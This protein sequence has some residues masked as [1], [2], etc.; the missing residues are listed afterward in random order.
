[1]RKRA[2]DEQTSVSGKSARTGAQQSA[3]HVSL[4]TADIAGSAYV[5][6]TKE[7]QRAYEHL[8][9]DIAALV[10]DVPH[11]MLS[12]FAEEVLFR[13]KNDAVVPRDKRRAVEREVFQ[14]ALTD[15]QYTMLTTAANSITDFVD[16]IDGAARGDGADTAAVDGDNGVSLVF[17]DDDDDDD[18][19]N[20]EG[21]AAYEVR[22]GSEDSDGDDR[23]DA[24]DVRDGG[25][26][27][28]ARGEDMATDDDGAEDGEIDPT[29]IDAHWLQRQV[30]KAVT[31]DAH[32][33]QELA[34][35]IFAALESA[36]D[37][38]VAE[39]ELLTLLQYDH[40]DLIKMLCVNR[41]AIVYCTRLLRAAG[42][43]EARAAIEEQMRADPELVR[44]LERLQRTRVA[45]ERV[46]PRGALGAMAA[47]AKSAHSKQQQQQQ[48]DENDEN[49]ETKPLKLLDIEAMAFAEGGHLM[50]N[51]QC[52][53]PPD[54][55]SV[56]GKGYTTIHIPARIAPKQENERL[57]PLEALPEWA[58]DGFAGMQSFN[59]VQS[60]VFETAFQGVDNMLIC[61]PTGSGKT[62]IAMLAIMHEL[63]MH[64]D[65]AGVL[66]LADF[67]IVYVAPMKALVQEVVQN[68]S[69]RLGTYG[70]VVRELS[71]DQNL[72]KQQIDETQIIVTTPE[73]WDIVTRKAGERTYTQLVRLLI[74]DEIHLLHDDRGP[75][76]EAL[77][78]RTIRQ[79]E[80]TQQMVRIV[81]LSATLPNYE[82]VATFLRVVPDNVFYFDNSYRPVPL[83]QT[84]IGISEKKG[85]KR[86]NLM[87]QICFERVMEHAI[88]GYTPNGPDGKPAAKPR[89]AAAADAKKGTQV[90]VF[91]H[92]RKETAATARMLKERAEA[93]DRLEQL[94]PEKSSALVLRTE[95]AKMQNAD[96]RELLPYGLG[97]HHAGLS[98]VD[99]T[100]VED[101]FADGHIRVLCS[102]ATLAWG[103]NLPA[104]AVVIKGTQVYNPEK[105]AWTELSIMDIMQMLGRAGRPA[106]DKTGE[107]II[108][109]S[110]T[111]MQFY[112]S[113]M[114]QQLPI[115]SQFMA[116]LADMMLGEIV[117]G[118]VGTIREAVEWLGYTY[119]YICMLRNPALYQVSYES[120]AADPLL[121]GRRADVAHSA[122]VL[123]ERCALIAYDKR[124]G[125]LRCTDAGRVA[126]HF[127]VSHSSMAT[128]HEHLKPSM[129][130]I[131]L[132][133][134]FALSSEFK[135]MSVRREERLELA[136]LLLRVPVPVKEGV[137]EHT[138]KVNVLLQA[139]ISRLSLDG[140]ALVADLVYVTQSAGRI[141]RA[142]YELVLK[143]GWAQLA[144]RVLLLAKML[145]Q[146]QWSTMSPLRQFGDVPPELIKR[147]ESKDF[148]LDRLNE[149]NSQEL[150]ALVRMPAQGAFLFERIHQCPRVSLAA[151]VQPLTRSMLRIELT[152]TP[153]FQYDAERHGP[154][155][156]F[157]VT[158]EDCDGEHILHSEPLVIKQRYA[159]DEHTLSFT[160]PLTDPLPPHYFVRV[161]ADRWLVPDALLP[162]SFAKLL[163][164]EQFPPHTELLDMAPIDVAANDGAAFGHN[165]AHAQHFLRRNVRQFNAI[166]TQTFK[167]LYG[168]DDSV[169]VAAPVGSGLSVCAELAVLRTLAEPAPSGKAAAA[170]GARV[171]YVVAHDVLAAQ[172]AATWTE[173]FA[174]LGKRVALFGADSTAN[175]AALKSSDIVVSTAENWDVVSRRWRQRKN[176]QNVRLYV[177]DQL[178]LI[179]GDAGA[180]LEVVVSRAR[181]VAAQIE[182]PTRIVALATPLANARTLAEWI[183][184]PSRACF[185]FVPSMRPVPLDLV[186]N[187]FDGPSNDAMLLAMSKPAVQTVRRQAGNDPVLVF[188]PDRR[189]AR[190]L[191]RDLITFGEAAR[192]AARAAN[193]DVA[194]EVRDDVERPFLHCKPAALE[195]HLEQVKLR[196]L[197]ESLAFGVGFY[198]EALEDGERRVV[199]QLFASGAVQVVVATHAM[200]YQLP[201]RARLVVV[202]GTQLFDGREHR[203]VDMPIAHVLHMM[204]KAGRQGVDRSGA[205]VIMCSTAKKAFFKK[206]LFEPLPVESHLDHTLADHFNAEVVAQTID[207]KQAAVD[208]LTWTF[209]Y[210]R[211]TQNPNYYGL[212]E[213]GPQQVSDHLSQLVETTLG[214]LEQSK[215]IAINDDADSVTPLNLGII[216]SYYH[217]RYT[218]IELFSLSLKRTTKLAAL[219]QILAE[220]SEY[221]SVPVRRGDERDMR[222]L[223]L[224]SPLK[225]ES[226]RYYDPHIKTNLLL[227]AHFSRRG[228][229]GDLARDQDEI[230]REAPRLVQAIVDVISSGGWL[231]PALAAMELSQMVA[232]AM[233]EKD[234]PL[235]QLPHVTR[236][237]AQ[238]LVDGGVQSVFD[239]LD[240]EDDDRRARLGALS[241]RQYA[242][243]AIACNRYPNVE[244]SYELHDGDALRAGEL[245]TVDVR[246]ARDAD[247]ADV[248]AD[249]GLVC[250]PFFPSPRTEAWWVL[251]G[252]VR[253]KKLHTIKRVTLTATATAQLQFLAPEEGEHALTLYAV[254]DSYMGC[255][256]EHEL[257]IRVGAGSGGG[258]AAS[259]MDA[260]E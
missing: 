129:S 210:R 133:R 113:L 143:R 102:T 175:L 177:F 235:I 215:C 180:T 240:L 68:L 9:R 65:E 123:L 183:G 161:A 11:E 162:L 217:I 195:A 112:L 245:V 220:A 130:D 107:G 13:L 134:L 192:A 138:A 238:S 17:A 248:A 229:L 136:K 135:H 48:Q 182:R 58:R 169:L 232:Q 244:V 118:T 185:S 124:T 77:V 234:S 79:I 39:N 126:S 3:A 178:Q 191:A 82:D 155:V 66:Q 153:D 81:G 56:P 146:R 91:V 97:V 57:V 4:L 141:V 51:K 132:L 197:R 174:A 74:I 10:G 75:V 38:R 92:S 213:L 233:W 230:L 219:L 236:E 108:I 231:L 84:F 253:S 46:A 200:A 257:A 207:S 67:K 2:A 70:I 23:S 224:H 189:T 41:K 63:A 90:L 164:A 33:A 106:F 121:K 83:Q 259:A 167:T 128:Y 203:Y 168:T 171:V 30:A 47:E 59:R 151:S 214:D 148:T 122:A 5:P 246:L 7:T 88:A 52:V 181:L 42:D 60:R 27:V 61:S 105:G 71:G 196:A 24:G 31:D 154:A 125:A 120:S 209:Y 242:D 36:S 226:E 86:F 104:H 241:D 32:K 50:S 140:Y 221:D 227:Q 85:M 198:H 239:L 20:D 250:A 29:T 204:G 179:G 87:N 216:A 1:M 21:V 223:A 110:Q 25:A 225:I 147:L 19:R 137:D 222:K 194:P 8:L 14:R 205:F 159:Q 249:G 22:D 55:V 40:F 228:L 237:L 34:A 12:G 218:T 72:T 62:N 80:A 149:L 156:G 163:L 184:A 15:E 176:V 193:A 190:Q 44:V 170:Q 117:L 186:M 35:Q 211:L 98:K 252:D 165:R 212:E 95:A 131:E 89:A 173:R 152:V 45:G 73:K 37:V 139:Y 150:G 16:D 243:V 114:N 43:A 127:Y 206:F 76:L 64:R 144:S 69:N 160:V 26:T 103:V 172:R 6:R 254:C 54:A 101:L 94:V 158:V 119:L 111:E 18:A 256:Q 201:L 199:E 202:M 251:V 115:E 96:L 116:R 49:G 255:D 99:R 100:L 187:G 166:Q 78:A 145:E 247:E 53:M 93:E 157:V 188:V 109:T 142:L 28:A 260:D 208:Y 258:G